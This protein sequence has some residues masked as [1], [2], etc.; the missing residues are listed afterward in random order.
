MLFTTTA[1]AFIVGL[2]CPVN[3]LRP[4][5]PIPP[6]AIKFATAGPPAPITIPSKPAFQSVVNPLIS[7]IDFTHLHDWIVRLTQFPDRYYKGKNGIDAAA[8]IVNGVNALTPPSG[9]KLTTRYFN[10]SG[11]SVPSVIARYEPVQATTL[12]GIVITGSHMD[13]IAQGAPSAEPYPNPAADDCSS[14]SGVVFE[15]LRTLVN[16]GFVPARPIEFHWYTA[17]E[18]GIYGSN[19]VAEAYAKAQTS[20]VSYL[21]LDQSGYVKSGTKAIMGLTTDYTT[22]GS[23]ALMGNIITTYSTLGYV[24][25]QCGYKCTDN[26]AWYDH[27]YESAMAFESDMSNATPYNDRVNSDGSPLD[28][29]ATLNFTHIGEFVKTTLAYV[30]EL[31]LTGSNTT[32]TISS[33]SSTA[34]P[35]KITSSSSIATSTTSTGPKA[36]YTVTVTVASTVSLVVKTNGVAATGLA[37]REREP[38][39]KRGGTAPTPTPTPTSTTPTASTTTVTVTVDPT[40]SLV[41][42]THA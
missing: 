21:N 16:G 33:A 22:S 6:E 36:S 27:S 8:W 38:L 9:A 2:T 24:K 10:H 37:R 18:E 25:T 1:V 23:T 41:V 7:Q 4:N 34:T 20:V 13:T 29:L 42:V 5:T 17:E 15:T 31:S 40:V 35:T 3:A 32:P 28:T 11:W 14:G 39:W 19:E 30:V 26:S 12:K